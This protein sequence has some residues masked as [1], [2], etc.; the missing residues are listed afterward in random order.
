MSTNNQ[1]ARSISTNNEMQNSASAEGEGVSLLTPYIF[2]G[3]PDFNADDERPSADN[4][5]TDALDFSFP[6]VKRWTLAVAPVKG[7]N[8]S[9]YP[10]GAAGWMINLDNLQLYTA[11]DKRAESESA[12]DGMNFGAEYTQ[13]DSPEP[14]TP[15]YEAYSE[16]GVYDTPIPVKGLPVEFRKV[17]FKGTAVDDNGC[18][19]G[20]GC[21]GYYAYIPCS[22]PIKQ[23]CDAPSGSGKCNPRND[24]FGQNQGVISDWKDFDIACGGEGSGCASSISS[25]SGSSGF[26]SGSGFI[27]SGCDSVITFRAEGCL[28]GNGLL[29]DGPVQFSGCVTQE[30][31]TGVI[32]HTL[33]PNLY[34]AISGTGEDM[35]FASGCNSIIGFK[36]SG[37]L[38]GSGQASPDGQFKASLHCDSGANASIVT[39]EANPDIYSR[40]E[41]ADSPLACFASG[42]ESTLR[43]ED[44]GCYSDFGWMETHVNCVGNETVV[45]YGVNPLAFSHVSGAG[46]TC[47]PTNCDWQL[48]FDLSGCLT[49]NNQFESALTCDTVNNT[50]I[51]TLGLQP[52]IYQRVSGSS[53][54]STCRPSGCDSMLAFDV[55]GCMTGN[56]QFSANVACNSNVT[57]VTFEANPDIYQ[58]ISGGDTVCR[59]DGCDS[60]LAFEVAGCLTGDNQFTREVSCEGDTTTVTFGI[61]PN[62]YSRVSANGTVCTANGCDSTLILETAG[63]DDFTVDLESCSDGDARVVFSLTGDA[64]SGGGCDS[65]FSNVKVGSTTYPA[66]DCESI[67]EFEATGCLGISAQAIT[68]GTKVSFGIT[69]GEILS[70][71]GYEEKAIEICEDGSAATYTF[72]VKTS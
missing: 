35:C 70:C 72:L 58:Q 47:T 63:C 26:C 24:N 61:D 48:A 41:A 13:S 62:M 9:Y 65:A 14:G 32:T 23:D 11:A 28:T 19:T 30:G 8:T 16:D 18:P 54:S 53:S 71:L 29:E 12:G 22:R 45:T 44:S 4:A 42:C 34:S 46:T 55:G 7:R 68:N 3:G 52:D 43:F 56:D 60:T 1:I 39:F 64:C 69:E 31:A 6:P 59:P 17:Y 21:V 2:M 15:C 38:T 33:N 40:V 36:T 27:A 10:D 50:A 20:S 66:D 49:G 57:T 67:V 5:P 37:C 25:I 51:V